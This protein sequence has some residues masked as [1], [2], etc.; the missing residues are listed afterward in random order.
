MNVQNGHA[1]T[2]LAKFISI[3]AE[4]ESAIVV[5]AS[6]PRF[7][8]TEQIQM[9]KL[10][11]WILPV[12]GIHNIHPNV[13]FRILVIKI[14]KKQV[15]AHK[16]IFIALGTCLPECIFETERIGG[17]GKTMEA[18]TVHYNTVQDHQAQTERHRRVEKDDMEREANSWREVVMIDLKFDA[19]RENFLDWKQS[20]H[21][22]CMPSL[23]A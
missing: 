21:P 7:M 12:R 6:D 18:S 10:T 22:C 15:I 19:Y 8:I 16:K 11:K 14:R 4:T 1:T 2:R 20:L 9:A 13:P 3:P 5:V 17:L 23:V